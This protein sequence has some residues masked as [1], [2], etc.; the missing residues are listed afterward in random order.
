MTESGG[1][2]AVLMGPVAKFIFGD[3]NTTLSSKREL[4]WGRNGSF[5]V[6]LE[7]G[8]FYDHEGETGGGLFDLIKREFSISTAAECF[9]WLEEN[10]FRADDRRPRPRLAY[11]NG[12][13]APH[14]DG[15]PGWQPDSVAGTSAA[16]ASA[17]AKGREVAWY[18]Y[19]DETGVLLFQVVRFEPKTF[20]QR[21][22]G[23]DGQWIWNL[24]GVRRIPYRLPELIEAIANGQ[25]VYIVEGEKDVENLRALG[26]VATCNPMGA[27]KWPDEF[28]QFFTGADVITIPDCDPPTKDRQGNIKLKDGKPIYPGQDHARRVCEALKGIANSVKFL[29]L[30]T[31]WPEI[32]EK[33]DVT[34]WIDDGGGTAEKLF[35]I[36]IRH[37]EYSPEQADAAKL[38]I[39]KWIDVRTWDGANIPPRDWIVQ[40]MIP[41]RNV[42]LISGQGGVGKTLLVQQLAI[43]TVMGLEWIGQTLFRAQRGPVMFIHCEDDEAEIHF[44]IAKMCE[45]FGV[46]LRDMG[47]F[48][49]VSLAGKESALATIDAKGIVQP[50]PLFEALRRDIEKIRPLWVAIDTA[51]DVFLIDERNR[52][53]V[54]QCI[55]LL[56]GLCLDLGTTVLLLAHPSI[57]GIKSGTGISG[58]TA[59]NNSVRSRLYLRLPTKKE[60]D[61]KNEK[62]AAAAAAGEEV[63]ENSDVRLLETMK[64]NYGP[65]GSMKTLKWAD[66]YFEYVKDGAPIALSPIN[67][68]TQAAVT[69]STVAEERFLEILRQFELVGRNVGANEGAQDKYYAPKAAATEDQEGNKIGWK[70]FKGCMERLIKR[71]EL[72]VLKAGSKAKPTAHLR[73][74]PKPDPQNVLPFKQPE[75]DK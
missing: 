70:M 67:G 42:T 46:S 59:W 22:R 50:T 24:E 55:G 9:A 38:P 26:V 17:P 13:G 19:L 25:Q 74:G 37:P 28:S 72:H 57:E 30:A 21:H 12:N 36:A 23:P 53:E 1:D 66:G 69:N 49:P 8:T 31:Y 43:S 58:S 35:E 6:D 44:R 51:A 75:K 34:N 32:P 45:K 63:D 4:R 2:L 33:G 5:A 73:V 52:S 56:R 41:T 54:R 40:D 20:R 16:A 14:D 15:A 62:N 47:D 3:P 11:S 61:V 68:G 27:G 65:S 39:I 7:K 29:N 48:Y 18:D 71:N 10:G 64:S 60:K